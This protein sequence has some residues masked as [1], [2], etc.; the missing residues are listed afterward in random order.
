MSF[1][2]MMERFIAHQARLPK[3]FFGRVIMPRIF[4][5]ANRNR[6][7]TTLRQL[8]LSKKHVVLDIGCGNGDFLFRLR[9][10]SPSCLAVGIELSS[11]MSTIVQQKNTNYEAGRGVAITR[12][13][14]NRLPFSEGSFDRV[15]ASNVIYFW[16]TPHESL[17][18]IHRV[19]KT[20]GKL[21]I[22]FQPIPPAN[23]AKYLS[24]GYVTY[25]QE[26]VIQ[27]LT[28]NGFRIVDVLSK[29]E[30]SKNRSWEV[31]WITASSGA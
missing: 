8:S 30:N 13:N 4:S 7:Q 6:H 28:D 10:H 18:E 12:A 27:L 29:G 2:N 3:G 15:V 20:N 9:Q 5:A 21:T 19:L 17:S 1:R 23:Q 24:Y 22:I 31:L 11:V 25:S 16:E 14:W 26:A